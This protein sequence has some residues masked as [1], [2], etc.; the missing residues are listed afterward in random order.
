MLFAVGD[1]DGRV[2]NEEIEEIRTIA[3]ALRLPHKDF[4]DAKLT[5]PKDRRSS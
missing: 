2:T 3:N 1:A 4:I 5:I